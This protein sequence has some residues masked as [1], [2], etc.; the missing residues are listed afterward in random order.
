M[1]VLLLLLLLL[2]DVVADDSEVLL[3]SIFGLT[4][5]GF[6]VQNLIRKRRDRNEFLVERNV[7]MI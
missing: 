6:K 7:M 4:A 2:S 1:D 3:F 5:V